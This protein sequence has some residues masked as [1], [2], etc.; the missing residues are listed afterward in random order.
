VF[1]NEHLEPG[2]F[3]S[4][5][6]EI[7]G[8]SGLAPG[9]VWDGSAHKAHANVHTHTHNCASVPVMATLQVRTPSHPPCKVASRSYMSGG[10]SADAACPGIPFCTQSS[11]VVWVRREK[12]AQGEVRREKSAQGEVRTGRGPH[13]ERSAGGG[14]CREGALQGEDPQV[15]KGTVP[16]RGVRKNL[17]WEM[18]PQGEGPAGKRGDVRK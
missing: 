18:S 3:S 2:C 9:S 5:S 10:G 15:G 7:T 12:S 16:G 8:L 1:S 14:S 4:A 13:R 11:G 6:Q 17:R